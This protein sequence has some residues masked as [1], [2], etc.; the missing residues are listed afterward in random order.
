[1]RVR[2]GP[3]TRPAPPQHPSST[4]GVVYPCVSEG[5]VGAAALPPHPSLHPPHSPSPRTPRCC[6]GPKSAARP[7]PPLRGWPPPRRPRCRRVPPCFL[8][9]LA[10]CSCCSGG[11][12]CSRCCCCCC[13]CC[14]RPRPV[15]RWGVGVGWGWGRVRVPSIC[16]CA[17]A[18]RAS[19]G[20]CVLCM[21][22][23][24]VVMRPIPPATPP[25]NARPPCHADATAH[26]RVCRTHAALTPLSVRLRWGPAAQHAQHMT[27]QRSVAAHG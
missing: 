15:R 2:T 18:A 21:L 26:G 24:G 6:P 1:M 25:D 8:P 13:R 23:G 14:C 20:S 11:A 17:A 16:I 3:P 22:P 4:M 7:R 27:E 19:E 9:F 10:C 5:S 12:R